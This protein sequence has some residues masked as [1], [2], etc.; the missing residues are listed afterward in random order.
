MFA[1]ATLE[2]KAVKKTANNITTKSNTECG[3]LP[4]LMR[5]F[6]SI[7]AMP[8]CLLPSASAKPPPM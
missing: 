6:P 2:L 3:K 8:L 5:E 1:I 7:G 4:R